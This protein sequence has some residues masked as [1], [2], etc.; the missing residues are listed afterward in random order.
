M[1][2]RWRDLILPEDCFDEAKLLAE[3]QFLLKRDD[4][5]VI[6][7]TTLG[8]VFFQDVDDA[9]Y[10]LDMSEG[11]FEKVITHSKHFEEALKN[12]DLVMEWFMPDIVEKL[13]IKFPIRSKASCF[14]MITLPPDGGQYKDDNYS[15]ALFTEHSSR[16]AIYYK[17]KKA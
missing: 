8:D 5:Q 11:T 14:T 7:V 2:I 3:W 13:T 1:T 15:F 9:V 17:Q 12:N 10:L 6:L 4:L 16:L